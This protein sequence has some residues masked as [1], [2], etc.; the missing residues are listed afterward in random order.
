[1]SE[2]LNIK[3]KDY[4]QGGRAEMLKYIPETAKKVLEIGCGEGNF[5]SLLKS[6]LGAEVWG[7]EYEPDQANVASKQIDKILCG[8]IMLLV[9]QLP[10]HYFDVI[11]CNDVLEH[12]TDPYTVLKKLKTKLTTKGV[13]VSSLPNI[14]Y[15]R[16]FFD[17]VF[18][19]NWDYTE[20]GI[21][22]FTHFRF[23]TINSIR[24][25]YENLDYEIMTLEGINP[26]KSLKP[27]P[28]IILTL[29]LFSDIKYLQFATVAKPKR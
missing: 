28:I 8:D 3:L 21:M 14:R 15:F 6:H 2:S 4:Y 26:T 11:I 20:R 13:V 27:W 24:K 19:R 9:D 12:L 1:M 17:L 5:G 18:R 29:G 7:I 10:E 16:N 22:D 23:F 25:M